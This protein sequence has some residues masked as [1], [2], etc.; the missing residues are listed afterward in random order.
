LLIVC[1][2]ILSSQVSCKSPSEITQNIQ[3]RTIQIMFVSQPKQGDTAVSFTPL[4]TGIL[5]N[6]DGYVI[7]ADHLLDIGEQYIQQARGEVKKMGIVILAPPGN[8]GFCSVPQPLT[9]I[10]DFDVIARDGKHDLALLKIKM[11]SVTSPLNGETLFTVQYN[12]GVSGTL[13]V[14]DAQ[15]STRIAKNNAIAVTGYTSNVV[16]GEISDQ[17]VPENRAGNVISKEITSINGSNLS[18]AAGIITYSISDYYQ[19]DLTSNPVIS[20]SPVYFPKNGA[21]IGMGISVA[22]PA[23]QTIIIPGKSILDLLKSNGVN[24]K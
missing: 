6:N 15:F 2:L 14:G 20:G 24:H 18:A 5:V 19:T 8:F 4:G 9:A 1:G 12:R 17:L 16:T 3:R 22:D 13:N 23:G 10:N 7:T 11:L 21:I